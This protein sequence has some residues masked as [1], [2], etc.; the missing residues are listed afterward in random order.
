MNIL[1]EFDDS[2]FQTRFRKALEPIID[3]FEASFRSRV[4][5]EFG[6]LRAKCGSVTPCV[7]GDQAD[8]LIG[9]GTV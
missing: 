4:A 2:G 5:G 9:N 1:L 6:N 8:D 7:G 3:N